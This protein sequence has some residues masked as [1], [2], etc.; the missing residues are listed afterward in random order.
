MKNTRIVLLIM[1]CVLSFSA[2]SQTTKQ[3]KSKNKTAVVKQDAAVKDAVYTD[4][5]GNKIIDNGKNKI[6]KK[7]NKK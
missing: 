6:A 4:H 7:I 1:L 3:K 2:Y 5:Y